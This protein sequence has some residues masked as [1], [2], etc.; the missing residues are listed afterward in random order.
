MVSLTK[1]CL[2][3]GASSKQTNR[4]TF[5]SNDVFPRGASLKH[6]NRCTFVSNDVFRRTVKPQ[7]GTK[8]RAGPRQRWRPSW[9]RKVGG[10][11]ITVTSSEL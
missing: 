11:V 6:A 2:M 3:I 9:A 7:S 5:V 8:A 10:Y 1:P 4:H